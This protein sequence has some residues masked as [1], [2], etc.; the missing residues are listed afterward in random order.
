MDVVASLSQGRT[1]AA[2]CDLFTYKSVP[3]IFE[4]PCKYSYFRF[5]AHTLTA[6]Y[7]ANTYI[8]LCLTENIIFY[9]NLFYLRLLCRSTSRAGFKG[10][11]QSESLKNL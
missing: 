5:N 7:Y 10:S 8:P 3:V 2:Q 4:P 1:A 11:L 6:L 9:L